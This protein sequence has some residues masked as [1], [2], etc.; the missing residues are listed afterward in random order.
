MQSY[1]FFAKN[2][3]IIVFSSS[4]FHNFCF[5]FYLFV[6]MFVLVQL[7]DAISISLLFLLHSSRCCIDVYTQY[8]II[9]SSLPH[10]P[11]S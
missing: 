3:H 10:P 11:F 6:L 7:A 4:L 9:V 1:T 8:P 5:C 2:V